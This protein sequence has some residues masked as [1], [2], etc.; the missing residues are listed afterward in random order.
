[1]AAALLPAVLRSLGSEMG[2]VL[3]F[4]RQALGSLFTCL[5]CAERFRNYVTEI[6]KPVAE[7][8]KKVLFVNNWHSLYDASPT[9]EIES[10]LHP[11][12]IR[13]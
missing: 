7:V 10:G 1:M 5:T 4:S 6:T 3:D 13:S 11:E 12:T 8:F 9:I 2:R